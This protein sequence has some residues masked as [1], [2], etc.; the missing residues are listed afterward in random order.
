[1]IVAKLS[2]QFS[3]VLQNDQDHILEQATKMMFF[4]NRLDLSMSDENQLTTAA[5]AAAA[6]RSVRAEQL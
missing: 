6:C 3:E 2:H 1:M 5:A 4:V